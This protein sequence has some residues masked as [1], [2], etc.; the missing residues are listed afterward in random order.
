MEHWWND[1]GREKPKYLN[2]HLSQCHFNHHRSHIDL[3]SK[4][5]LRGKR[6]AINNLSHSTHLQGKSE[7]R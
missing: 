3:E 5:G 2:K 6:L 1:I 4:P 7:E